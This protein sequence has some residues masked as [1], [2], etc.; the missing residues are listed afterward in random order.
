MLKD[1]EVCVIHSSANSE[2][3]V[4]LQADKSYEYIL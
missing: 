3:K 2:N 1:S 4:T